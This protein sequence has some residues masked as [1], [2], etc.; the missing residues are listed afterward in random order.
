MIVNN[1]KRSTTE[2]VGGT[3]RFRPMPELRL[4]SRMPTIQAMANA[5]PVEELLAWTRRRAE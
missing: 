3:P 4:T 5:R 1:P 2:S